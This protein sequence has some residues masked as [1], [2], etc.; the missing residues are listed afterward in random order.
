MN[1]TGIGPKVD[2]SILS[3]GGRTSGMAAGPGSFADTLRQLAGPAADAG[4]VADQAV[5]S[6]AAG[7]PQELHTV[8]LA[9]Q[10]A[11]VQFQLLLNLRNKLVHAYQEIMQMQV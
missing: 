11:E 10:K 9:M 2:T 1:V 8:E 3:E 5:S 6:L 4:R 7:Q